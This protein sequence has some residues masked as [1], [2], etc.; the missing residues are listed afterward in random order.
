MKYP[1]THHLKLGIKVAK[2]SNVRRGK[3]CAMAFSDQGELIAFAHNRKTTVNLPRR[4]WTEHAEI[5]LIN[6]L[7]RIRAFFRYDNITILVLRI[8]SM[9]M[10]MA[11]PCQRCQKILDQYPVTI[12]Y[13]DWNGQICS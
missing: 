11:K 9:S 3:L 13:S 1:N 10:T 7:K 2:N 12:L 4:V 8:N 6:K 5:A